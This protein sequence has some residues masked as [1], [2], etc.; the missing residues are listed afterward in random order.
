MRRAVRAVLLALLALL[1]ARASAEIRWFRSD[2]M[3]LAI[4]PI[5]AFRTD[6][7]TWILSVERSTAGGSGWMETRRLLSGGVEERRWTIVRSPDGKTEEREERAGVIAARRRTGAAG[8]LLQEELFED[9]RPS[10]RSVY[11]YASGRLGRVRVF[12]AD[13]SLSSTVEYLTAPSGRLREVRWT[14]ADGSLRT[15]S[16]AAGGTGSV[17]GGAALA[18]ERAR[19]GTEWR[20]IRY[21][22]AGRAAVLEQGGPDGLVFRRRLL[23]A[24][25]STTPASSWTEWPA[26]KRVVET[27]YDAGGGEI[28]ETT[29]IAGIVT[30]RA[31]WSR[32]EAGR[33]LVVRRTGTGGTTEVRTTWAA[34]GTLEREEHFLRGSR[35]KNVIHTAANERVE[36][37]FEDGEMFLRVQYR[38]DTRVREEVILDGV[39]VRERTFAP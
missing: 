31:G 9:G 7:F 20:T 26:E 6:E 14:A 33:V 25:S 27:Q 13:G 16:Q 17:P 2:E 19:E 36:E 35:V 22:E 28:S 15:E 21:D 24:G 10:S 39:V 34:D 38:G 5:P 11:E 4:E 3:G 30:E 12:A 18:E 1:A 8:E 37:L 23:Y 32:D 29:T